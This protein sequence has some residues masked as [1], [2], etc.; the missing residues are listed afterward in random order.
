MR[1]V[2]DTN[3][4]VSAMLIP[5]SVPDRAFAGAIRAAQVM[6][7]PLTLKELSEVLARPRIAKYI[8]PDD[9]DDVLNSLSQR[10][11]SIDPTV[12]I[13]ACRDPKDDKFLELAVAGQADYIVS[14][15]DDLL[16]LNPF[17]GVEILSPA[18]FLNRLP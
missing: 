10:A 2:F 9:R 16:D 15:D 13:Q 7:S 6:I 8:D 14:G 12:S 3:V 17:Q 11:H 5:A 1:V 4:L 18:E